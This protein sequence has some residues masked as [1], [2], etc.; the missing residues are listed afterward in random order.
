MKY[1]QLK[2]A[3]NSLSKEELNKDV[4]IFTFAEGECEILNAVLRV[5]EKKGVDAH[6]SDVV[7][8]ELKKG[9][10][11]LVCG[12]GVDIIKQKV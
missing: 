3:L 10:P 12:L 6:C 5:G 7:M 2:K 1:I 8:G 11:Y 9:E 4:H